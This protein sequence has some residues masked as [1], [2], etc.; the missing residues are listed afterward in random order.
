M[1]TEMSLL[2]TWLEDKRINS[3]RAGNLIPALFLSSSSEANS[4]L[5][6]G[7]SAYDEWHDIRECSARVSSKIR[8]LPS[9]FVVVIQ[10]IT[11]QG[12]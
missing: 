2:G 5:K 9:Q 12:Y 7:D 4:S 8:F 6:T 3:K 11:F 10:C 1:A